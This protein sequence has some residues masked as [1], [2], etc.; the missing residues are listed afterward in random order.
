MKRG[1]LYAQELV[2]QFVSWHPK[3]WIKEARVELKN[4]CAD[5]V[6]VSHQQHDY[7]TRA[8]AFSRTTRRSTSRQVARCVRLGCHCWS[9]RW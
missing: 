3:G 2:S 7:Q 9:V 1:L 8:P 6:D 5:R 4:E